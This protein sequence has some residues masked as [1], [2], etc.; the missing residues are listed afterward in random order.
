MMAARQ[1]HLTGK[2][3]EE[4]KTRKT[5]ELDKPT[6]QGSQTE[7]EIEE[8]QEKGRESEKTT[9]LVHDFPFKETEGLPVLEK[10]QKGGAG[11]QNKAPLQ[12]DERARE[13]LRNTL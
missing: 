7:V 3:P 4:K 12:A 5:V 1:K 11:F 6:Q 2:P 9:R 13:L 10:D 8:S